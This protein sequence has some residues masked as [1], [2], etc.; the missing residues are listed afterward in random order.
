MPLA[1]DDY[2]SSEMRYVLHT[3]PSALLPYAIFTDDVTL[4]VRD[5]YA[6]SGSWQ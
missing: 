5:V 1:V 4:R 6:T 3:V 2:I